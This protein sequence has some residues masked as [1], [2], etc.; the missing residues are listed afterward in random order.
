MSF[1][2]RR[3]IPRCTLKMTRTQE[4]T[5]LTGFKAH[6]TISQPARVRLMHKIRSR[7][8][9]PAIQSRAPAADVTLRSAMRKHFSALALLTLLNLNVIPL[10]AQTQAPATSS[11]VAAVERRVES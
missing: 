2:L 11:D 5:A 6:H 10:L 9:R 7:P 4:R 8:A 3:G 1:P